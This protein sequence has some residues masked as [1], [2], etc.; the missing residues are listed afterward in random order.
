MNGGGAQQHLQTA[1]NGSWTPDG[2]RQGATKLIT[3]VQLAHNADP[4]KVKVGEASFLT[5]AGLYTTLSRLLCTCTLQGKVV[6]TPRGLE[7]EWPTGHAV[8]IAEVVGAVEALCSCAEELQQQGWR[9]HAATSQTCLSSVSSGRVTRSAAA[10]AAVC[11]GDSSCTMSDACNIPGDDAS[12][13]RSRRHRQR[14]QL[15]G[16]QGELWLSHGPQESS[17]SSSS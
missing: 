13:S 9:Q 2:A 15:S 11:A 14:A 17:N 3:I 12:S 4:W 7:F 16:S 10:A 1:G 6:Q 5:Y 8:L